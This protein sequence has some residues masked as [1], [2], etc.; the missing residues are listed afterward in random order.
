VQ[1]ALDQINYHVLRLPRDAARW[2]FV[3]EFL[4]LRKQVFVDRM[5]WQLDTLDHIEF[6]QYD[7]LMTTYIIAEDSV[8]SR[9]VGGARLLRTDRRNET[10]SG[11][12]KYSYMIRDAALGLLPGLPSEI[13][14][15]APPTDAGTWELTRLV[16]DGVRGVAQGILWAVNSFL[17]LTGANR[18]LFLGPPS[19]LRMAKSM[20]F[21]PKPMGKIVGNESGRFLAFACDVIRD[22]GTVALR[23]CG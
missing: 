21:S 16:V 6:E 10:C 3:H 20:G 18:C 2:H 17:N 5:Q 9:V 13:T 7:H 8:T 11:R 15:G 1:F 12:L 4:R 14:E 19:F 23:A 22:N